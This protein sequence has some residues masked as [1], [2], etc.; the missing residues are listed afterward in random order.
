M[1]LDNSMASKRILKELKYLEKNPLSC[2]SVRLVQ[3]DDLFN[4]QATIMGPE[5]SPY[6]GGVFNLNIQFPLDYP[7]KPPKVNFITKIYHPN[8]GIKGKIHGLRELSDDWSQSLTIG[9]ILLFIQSMLMSISNLDTY[10]ETSDLYFSPAQADIMRLYLENRE[11]FNE[12][13]RE[14]T[15]KYAIKN[16]SEF[17]E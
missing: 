16:F 7:F 10:K 17:F 4:L 12:I 9:K 2:C 11:Q 5:N 14:W 3:S 15:K 13:A 6:E 8:I 1:I